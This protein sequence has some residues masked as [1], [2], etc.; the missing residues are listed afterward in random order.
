MACSLC[1]RS[2]IRTDTAGEFP[3][4]APKAFPLPVPESMSRAPVQRLS[5]GMGHPERRFWSVCNGKAIIR[6]ATRPSRRWWV[7]SD[8]K[9]RAVGSS[10][11]LFPA[12][13]VVVAPLVGRLLPPDLHRRRLNV[14]DPRDL[15]GDHA[16]PVLLRSLLSVILGL[17]PERSASP[18]QAGG[19]PQEYGDDCH[20]DQQ[21]PHRE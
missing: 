16:E 21:L 7:G 11:V 9:P 8:G 20:N 5:A 18:E 10:V 14:R 6:D 3:M 1:P 2:R 15:R 17:L 12:A 19:H 4:E 13:R